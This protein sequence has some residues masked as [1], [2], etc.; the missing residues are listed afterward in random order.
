[1]R[2]VSAEAVSKSVRVGRLRRSVGREG[3][4]RPFIA[5][6]ALANEEWETNGA[7]RRASDAAA[8]AVALPLNRFSLFPIGGLVVFS[9]ASPGDDL[10]EGL[11]FPMAAETACVWALRLVG[12]LATEFPDVAR[13]MGV[14]R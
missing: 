6:V 11:T 10:D 13:R 7:A 14:I 12:L 5:D 9:V 3:D 2:G 1:M 8:A 4:G